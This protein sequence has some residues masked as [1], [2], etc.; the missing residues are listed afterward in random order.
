MEVTCP[1]I[2]YAHSHPRDHIRYAQISNGNSLCEGGLY[3]LLGC[4]RT[5]LER[6]E[7]P[8]LGGPCSTLVIED[9]VEW[10]CICSG[11]ESKAPSGYEG[12]ILDP[13]RDNIDNH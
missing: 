1:A 7:K 10:A 12:Q 13:H 5:R 4:Q 8:L 3:C 9:M 11:A 2:P 6:R